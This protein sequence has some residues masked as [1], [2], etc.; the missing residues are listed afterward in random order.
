[1]VFAMMIIGAITR[2]TES[3]LSI[4]EWNVVMG[5]LPPRTPAQWEAEFAL[6]KQSPEFL[7]KNFWMSLDDF[8]NIF[9]WEWFHRLWGRLIGVVFAVP[10]AFFWIRG[11]IPPGYKSKFLLLL[12]LGSAQGF[13]G[14][15]MV[16]SGLIDIPAVSHYRL[17][18]HLSLAFI[19]LAALL[20]LA[21]S[22]SPIKKYPHKALFMHGLI[23]LIFL[24]ITIAWGAFTAGLDA[25]L[26]YNETFPKMGGQWIPP[27][28]WAKDTLIA[29]LLENHSAVQFAHRWLAMGTALI[30]LSL[31]AHGMLKAQR[32]PVLSLVMMMVVLQ[33]GMGIA[34]LLSGV[35][36][37]IATAHQGGAAI[38]LSLLV[39]FLYQTYPRPAP[40]SQT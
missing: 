31:W 39:L 15:Y 21:F 37:H 5:I 30:M 22:L 3:G 35:H 6:Y 38:L 29:N 27:D 17:A 40:S 16:Q 24:S 25:G 26:V 11:M 4:V 34:T 19:I 1:M 18:A 8:K 13:M 10:L 28:F 33:T 20:V 12:L 7:K 32:I 2:L 23:A 36:L 14:W 9:F